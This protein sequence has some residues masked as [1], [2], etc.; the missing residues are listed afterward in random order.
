[1]GFRRAD[2]TRVNLCLSFEFKRLEREMGASPALT[3]TKVSKAG[4]ASTPACPGSP[5]KRVW[6]S[7]DSGETD[8]GEE[9]QQEGGE[10][11]KPFLYHSSQP[12]IL[13]YHRNNDYS[14]HILNKKHA[15]FCSFPKKEKKLKY[16]SKKYGLKHGKQDISQTTYF[17]KG[18]NWYVFVYDTQRLQ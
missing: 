5:V 6:W 15:G 16:F 12:N 17:Y 3:P 8:S 9:H 2:H 18:C 1:M 10:M 11:S 7:L 14:I 13:Y 4:A